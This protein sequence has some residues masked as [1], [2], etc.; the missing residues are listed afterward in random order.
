VRLHTGSDVGLRTSYHYLLSSLG[1]WL[2]Q[3]A[4]DSAPEITTSKG[5]R[6]I[7]LALLVFVGLRV[8]GVCSWG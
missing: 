7:V 2:T 6:V 8:G 5:F 3:S 4:T 1:S